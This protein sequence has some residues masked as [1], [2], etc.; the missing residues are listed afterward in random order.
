[1][2]CQS[3]ERN[4]ENTAHLRSYLEIK[5]SSYCNRSVTDQK[6]RQ[7]KIYDGREIQ[8]QSLLSAQMKATNFVSTCETHLKQRNSQTKVTGNDIS[9]ID[10]CL[11]LTLF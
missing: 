6:P 8:I 7:S 3:E 9:R 5:C 2:H 11:Q 10:Q 4:N 1:M